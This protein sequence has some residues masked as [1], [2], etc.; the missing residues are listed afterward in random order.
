MDGESFDLMV[1]IAADEW[2]YAQR[3]MAFLEV[4][5][6]TFAQPR[7]LAREW[8]HAEELAGL[9]LPGLPRSGSGIRRRAAAE[10]WTSR[11][12]GA[13]GRTGYHVTSLPPRAFEALLDRLLDM[14]SAP[15]GQTASKELTM[16]TALPANTAP[17]WVLPL[18]RLM[19]K[20]TG[21]DLGRAW[22]SLP[23]RLPPGATLPDVQEA[24]RILMKL[25]LA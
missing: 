12:I 21:G 10:R 24:A 11:R 17:P 2:A 23:A 18:L 6:V 5:A 3:R 1:T 15:G 16:A 19:R 25:G 9:C 22:R 4:L 14:P 8:Y 7:A 20:E 13:A